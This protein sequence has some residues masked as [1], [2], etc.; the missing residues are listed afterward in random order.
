[1]FKNL[2]VVFFLVLA[3]IGF[4][5]KTIAQSSAARYYKIV[6]IDG[7][8]TKK[9][10]LWGHINSP[11]RYE[12]PISTNLVELITYAGGPREYA[13][14]DDIKIYRTDQYG[15]KLVLTVDLDN[16]SETPDSDLIIYDGDTV[17]IDY[18]SVVTWR[19][20]FSLISGPLAMIASIVLIVD[21]LSSK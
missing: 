15:R 10:N 1:M 11:G 19:D 6:D 18:S 4:S 8:V 12:V 17:Y 7:E 20:V 9:I 21:R 14:M 5:E 3:S 2:T 16:P 13:L